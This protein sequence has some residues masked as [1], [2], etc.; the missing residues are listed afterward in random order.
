MIN[1][2]ICAIFYAALFTMVFCVDHKKQKLIND[3]ISIRSYTVQID[4]TLQLQIL[5]DVVTDLTLL[6]RPY[7]AKSA[8][9]YSELGHGCPIACDHHL[10]FLNGM[11]RHSTRNK[12]ENKKG[13]LT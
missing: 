4:E 3:T 13:V 10:A 2:L 1:L 6:F 12:Y 11:F 7:L 9:E 8:V 5:S